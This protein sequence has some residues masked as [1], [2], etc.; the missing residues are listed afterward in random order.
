MLHTPATGTFGEQKQSL[1]HMFMQMFLTLARTF[2]LHIKQGS[3]T[4]KPMK[5]A[6]LSARLRWATLL[7]IRK[8]V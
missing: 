2:A 6:Q 3:S 4:L 5:Q 1:S 7:K 8:H